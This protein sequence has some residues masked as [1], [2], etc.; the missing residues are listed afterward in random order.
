MDNRVSRL[1]LASAIG[2]TVGAVQ[3]I[4]VSAATGTTWWV[5]NQGVDSASCGTRGKPCRSI[6]AAIEKAADGDVIEVGA[7]LY[8]DLDGDG[9]FTSPGEEHYSTDNDGRSCIVCIRKAIKVLSLHGADDTIISAGSGQNVDYV[10]GII[11][12]GVTLGTDGG[13]FTVSGGARA[14]VHVGFISQNDKIIGNTA[15][16]NTGAGFDLE[17]VDES[18]PP[19]PVPYSQYTFDGNTA[20]GNATGF[21]VSHDETHTIPERVLFTGNVAIGNANY[22]FGLSGIGFQ[23][24]FIGNVANN[25]GAGLYIGGDRYEIRNSSIM[26]N[27]GPGILINGRIGGSGL[28]ITGNSI[29]GNQGAGVYVLPDAQGNTIRNNNI[30]GNGGVGTA[31]TSPVVGNT[32][33]CGIVNTGFDLASPEA[34]I[35]TNN[36]WG[37]ASGPG[38]DPADNAGKGC[39]FNQGTTVVKPFATTAYGISP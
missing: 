27:R 20:T 19:F 24:Q 6:S 9:A 28:M 29:I 32:L 2:L 37:S 33:N 7:G 16:G 13:G 15:R 25:N 36:Y 39:D 8:G 4:S 11:S 26:G 35:A 14:G 3:S 18:A 23:L 34:I 5:T 1:A 17:V 12:S 38:A 30:Y 21:N 10:V 22:G 31:F